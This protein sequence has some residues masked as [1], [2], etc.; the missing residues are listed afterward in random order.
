MQMEF[1]C[2]EQTK[3][4]PVINAA[5]RAPARQ[6]LGLLTYRVDTLPAHVL[7]CFMQGFDSQWKGGARRRGPLLRERW[8]GLLVRSVSV[9]SIP[10]GQPKTSKG[11]AFNPLALL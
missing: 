3:A 8:G 5:A 9:N 11:S 2:L 1:V 6:H 4:P 7:V 10:T